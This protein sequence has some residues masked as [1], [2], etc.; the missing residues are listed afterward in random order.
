MSKQSRDLSERKEIVAGSAS[1]MGRCSM[2]SCP[3][4]KPASLKGSRFPKQ[5]NKLIA[6]STKWW[7]NEDYLIS[8]WVL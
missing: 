4:A 1:R 7:S 6:L 5:T 2:C 3:G 8:I